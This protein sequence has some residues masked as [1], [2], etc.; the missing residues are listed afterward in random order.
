MYGIFTYSWLTSMVNVGRYPIHGC[1]GIYLV[2]ES[3][4]THIFMAGPPTSHLTPLRNQG[5]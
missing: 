3:W 4:K 1:C 2:V 5:L